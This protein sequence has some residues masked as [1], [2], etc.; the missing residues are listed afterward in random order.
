MN[1]M[2]FIARPKPSKARRSAH[3]DRTRDEE[4]LDWV[5]RRARG[6]SCGSIARAYGV[7]RGQVVVATT[8]V[9]KADFAECGEVI[10]QGEY[11]A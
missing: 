6:E 4:V 5:T 9:M 7:S 8:N 1:Q 3:P 10:W 2:T 11:W